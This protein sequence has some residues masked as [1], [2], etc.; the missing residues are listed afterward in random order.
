[1][2]MDVT[3][4]RTVQLRGFL[5]Q[6]ANSV[7]IGVR[8]GGV[9]T[10]YNLNIMTSG[11]QEH[12][13]FESL[14]LN[15]PDNVNTIY[16]RT[17]N[18]NAFFR[19]YRINTRELRPRSYVLDAE[20]YFE[21][22][23]L[24]SETSESDYFSAYTRHPVMYRADAD[25]DIHFFVRSLREDRTGATIEIH[26]NSQLHQTSII[27]NRSATDFRVDDLEVSPGLRIE[28]KD[29]KKGDTITIFPRTEHIII[30]R[31]F[32]TTKEL[33]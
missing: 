27:P 7:D 19:H 5:T 12:Y 23:V 14:E 1:M 16:V 21:R 4:V 26:V 8:I 22:R 9:E 24:I 10:R 33:F 31:M 11:T 3:G 20:S 32:L 30:T 6:K 29:V 28:I 2:E 18:P 13:W 25:G 17:R 15:I